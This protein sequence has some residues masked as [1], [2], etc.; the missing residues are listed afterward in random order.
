MKVGQLAPERYRMTTKVVNIDTDLLIIG[1]GAAGCYAAVEAKT[2]EPGVR[3]LI[4][5]KAH[6][7]RSGCLAMGLNSINAYLH[8]GQDP[9]SYLNYVKKEC[10][11]VLREDLV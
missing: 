3:C 5:E 11:D 1:G 9:G 6:I 8:P 10:M 2:L 7:D 4:M